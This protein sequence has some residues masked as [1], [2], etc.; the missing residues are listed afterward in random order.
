MGKALVLY[1][2]ASG[3]TIKMAALVAEGAAVI[4]GT[5]ARVREVDAVTPDN[6]S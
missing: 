4:P 1:H 5:E 6:V 3:N 2:S